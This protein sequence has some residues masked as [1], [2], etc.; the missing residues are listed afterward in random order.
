[1]ESL[2]PPFFI[3]EFQGDFLDYYAIEFLSII[4]FQYL[5][6]KREVLKP[7]FLDFESKS[8]LITLMVV[9]IAVVNICIFCK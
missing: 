1:M 5:N 6:D 7:L 3:R 2:S 9:V 4:S 8:Q